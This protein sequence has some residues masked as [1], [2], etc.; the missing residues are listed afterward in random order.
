MSLKCLTYNI[1]L[2]PWMTKK[3]YEPFINLIKDFDIILLQEVFDNFRKNHGKNKIIEILKENNFFVHSSNFYLKFPILCSGLVIASKYPIYDKHFEKFL[4]SS[5]V[6]KLARKGILSCKIKFNDKDLDIINVHTQSGYINGELPC[7]GTHRL[8]RIKQFNQIN[9]LINP[10]LSIKKNVILGGDFNF[11]IN[12]YDNYEKWFF[13]FEEN[14]Y[15]IN[16]YDMILSTLKLN[17]INCIDMKNWS[18]H[19]PIGVKIET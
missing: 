3:S 6:D 8:T 2:L 12:E 11:H 16:K 7:T 4:W 18:D 10:L 17:K 15:V 9:K 5:S 19:E 1:Q 14:K 13:N